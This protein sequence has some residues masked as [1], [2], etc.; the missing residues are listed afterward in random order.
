ME[1]KKAIRQRIRRERAHMDEARWI[2]DT[3]KITASVIRHPWF[4]RES[5]LY[6]YVDYNNEVGTRLIMAE[7]LRR[8]MNVWVPRVTG[9]TMLFCRIQGMDELKAGTYG[10]LEPIGEQI[11]EAEQGLMIMPGVAFDEKCHRVG[12][13]KGFYDRY[14]KGRKVLRR[15]AVG[16]EFQVFGEVPYEEHDICPEILITEQRVIEAGRIK[17]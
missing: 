15:M 9:N 13:G 12:Y 6:I 11:G 14:L 4:V 5:D 2:R 16:F 1:S 3:E 10:I 17:R 8:G 7:A